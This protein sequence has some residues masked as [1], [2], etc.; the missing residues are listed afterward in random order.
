[1][2]ENGEMC[3]GWV[4]PKPADWYYLDGNG[5]MQ[6]GWVNVNGR[7]YY[8]D[9]SG[10]MQRGWVMIAGV[11]YYFNGDGSMATNTWLDGWNIGADGAA[12]Q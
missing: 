9:D 4:E 10:K 8:L 6:R 12:Y 7:W 3:T 5:Y 2:N 11:W 1:M